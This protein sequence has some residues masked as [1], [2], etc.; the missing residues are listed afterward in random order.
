MMNQS[1][2]LDGIEKAV[3]G[4]GYKNPNTQKC[5]LIQ[6]IKSYYTDKDAINE[7]ES[8]PPEA[9]ISAVWSTETNP[10]QIRSKLKNLNSIKSSI[11]KDLILAFEKGT[12]PEGIIIGSGYLFDMSDEAKDQFIGSMSGALSAGG[13]ISIEQ[14]AKISQQ[15]GEFLTKIPDEN[16][17]KFLSTL[18][19]SL[20]SDRPLPPEEIPQMLNLFGNLLSHIPDHELL[21]E[22]DKISELVR[23]L[24]EKSGDTAIEN[25][26]DD[27]VEVVD[28]LVEDDDEAVGAE[29]TGDDDLE[30][31]ED[32]GELEEIDEDELI[33]EL[34]EDESGEL[35]EFE[36]IDDEGAEVEEVPDEQD[37]S[38]EV[39]DV[40]VEDD[41]EA[42]EAEETGDDDLEADEDEGELEEIDEDELIEELVEDES[43]ELDEFETIDD[44][45]AEVEEVLDEVE[46]V[47]EPV[48][49]A[50]TPF[51]NF[52]APYDAFMDDDLTL[53]NAL[54]D[55]ERKRLLAERFERY[56]GEI[57][58]HY[59]QYLL[60][61]GGEYII[62]AQNIRKNERPIRKITISDIF[63]GRFP[64]TNALFEVFVERTGYKT[65]A[66]ECGFGIVYQGRFQRKNDEISGQKRYEWN[67]TSLWEE[68]ENAYWYQPSG[69]GSTLHLK[70][71]HPV[72]QVSFRDAMAFASWV[73]KR[74]PSEAEWEAAARTA[75]GNIYP[76]GNEWKEGVCNTEE[77]EISD[78]VPVDNFSNAKNPLGLFDLLGNTLEWTSDRWEGTYGASTRQDYR[79]VK[80]GSWVSSPDVTLQSWFKYPT[81]FTANI[82]GFRCLAD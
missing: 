45:G 79:I 48:E 46:A 68:R 75:S 9:L 47:A 59:N 50:E 67:A 66:E 21:K 35:D 71:N 80:G 41:D 4:L 20:N 27:S 82:L 58:K 14:I 39:V 15:F 61:P 69:P 76:W 43:G 17:L 26:P 70:R 2:S 10:N 74:L 56:L 52:D 63:F 53:N 33:E 22:K 5:R 77:S 32:E 36:T 51:D 11:N 55:R 7:V 62:G 6:A 29:E 34:V 65:T 3:S 78:T 64:V 30:A 18:I 54:S 49:D 31:D 8:I 57:E 28:V 38:V 25:V 42:V 37:D 73:G 16:V 60:I 44:E 24:S 13:P 19:E 1:I 72:V 23:H 40:L 81:D 12:N